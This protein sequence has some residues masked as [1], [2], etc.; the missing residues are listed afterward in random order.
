MS[1]PHWPR[2]PPTARGHTPVSGRGGTSDGEETQ[3]WVS[4][5]Y[6]F[7]VTRRPAGTT[8][9]GFTADGMPVGLQI[10]GHQLDDLRTL[11]VTAW[12]EDLLGFDPVAP[13]PAQVPEHVVAAPRML[14]LAV[15]ERALGQRFE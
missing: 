2:P 7:N 14:Q 9:A 5:T 6:P 1:A 15:V 8:N 4:Y 12:I 13:L 3:A 11:E 10:V